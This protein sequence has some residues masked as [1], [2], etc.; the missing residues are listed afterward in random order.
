MNISLIE[1]QQSRS[2]QESVRLKRE[3]IEAFLEDSDI[4]II[5]INTL[6]RALVLMED[7][8][9]QKQWNLVNNFDNT[10]TQDDFYEYILSK[11]HIG[12]WHNRVS[13]IK[14]IQKILDTDVS[15]DDINS[16]RKNFQT[17]VS[18]LLFPHK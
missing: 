4:E 6:V 9:L 11:N 13:I 10:L 14:Y 17:L 8:S 3:T 1:V 7:P 5:Y 12:N 18:Y 16:N 2:F 15:D